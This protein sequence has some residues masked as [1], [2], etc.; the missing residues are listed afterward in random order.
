MI[1]VYFQMIKIIEFVINELD[2]KLSKCDLFKTKQGVDFVGYRHFPQYTLVRKRTAKKVKKRMLKIQY[3]L[4]NYELTQ[5]ELF[6]M[7]GKLPA[8]MVGVNTLILIDL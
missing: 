6:R 4:K 8:H 2:M 5:K 7:N 1:F 3:K